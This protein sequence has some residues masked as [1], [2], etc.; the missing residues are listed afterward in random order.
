MCK[1]FVKFVHVERF[2]ILCTELMKKILVVLALGWLASACVSQRSRVDVN[3][4]YLPGSSR[5]QTYAIL[6][7]GDFRVLTAEQQEAVR[8]E[9]NRQM[10]ARGYRQV[11]KGADLA[12]VFSLYGKACRWQE[13]RLVT[14]N[15]KGNTYAAHKKGTLLI[16]MVDENLNRSVWMGYASGLVASSEILEDRELKAATRQILDEYKEMAPG[17]VRRQR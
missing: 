5:N 9:I 1:D 6:Q 14:E 16:Q 7:S 4:D 10:Q 17:Y 3:D 15:S 11:E 13:S 2:T 8:E 12:I